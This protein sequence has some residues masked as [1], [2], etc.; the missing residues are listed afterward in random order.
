M[1]SVAHLSMKRSCDANVVVADLDLIDFQAR[2]LV[3]KD[4]TD[5]R[6]LVGNQVSCLNARGLVARF[7]STPGIVA[8]AQNEK[9]DNA[10]ICLVCFVSHSKQSLSFQITGAWGRPKLEA[11]VLSTRRNI[12]LEETRHHVDSEGGG[13]LVWSETD[14]FRMPP[15]QTAP[16][17]EVVE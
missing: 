7:R 15:G 8:R 10:S 17:G 16:N 12:S 11:N 4:Y 2:R 5:V 6:I 1:Q 3:D 13:G 14:R 9:A